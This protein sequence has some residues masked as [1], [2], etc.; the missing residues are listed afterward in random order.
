MTGPWCER[1][2]QL[3]G[4]LEGKARFMRSDPENDHPVEVAKYKL[5]QE[6]ADYARVMEMEVR[7]GFQSGL[8]VPTPASEQG[9]EQWH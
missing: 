1:Y 6:V 4:Y 5:I 3:L 8:A 2:Y 7:N 9:D